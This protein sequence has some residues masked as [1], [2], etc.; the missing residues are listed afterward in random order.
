[1]SSP[2]P[3]S[4]NECTFSTLTLHSI[5][6]NALMRAESSTPAMPSTRC[7]GK[8]LTLNAACAIAS[9]GFVTTMMMQF[10]RMLDDLLDDRFHHI[11]VG[12]QQ[13]VAATFPACAEIPR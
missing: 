7:F 1:M 10:G 5:A 9:S 6:T 11:V 13:I 3:P 2:C 12:L 4:T 8:P